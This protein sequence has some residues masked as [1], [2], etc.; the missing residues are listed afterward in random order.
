MELPFTTPL[1]LNDRLHHMVKAKK[2]SEWRKAASVALRAAQVPS[3]AR[4]RAGLAYYPA[5]NRR[6]DPDNLVA[7]MKPVVD[8]LVDAGVV[9]D[10]TQ[11]F[12]ERTWPVIMPA[13]PARQGGR[14]VLLVERLA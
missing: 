12:V 9:P 14:F 10:D 1:S 4:V 8:A 7:T 13:E 3:C 6:R 2:V 11:E 5:Q